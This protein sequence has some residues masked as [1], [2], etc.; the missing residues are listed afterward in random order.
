MYQCELNVPT[1]KKRG[2]KMFSNIHMAN[3]LKRSVIIMYPSWEN[4][5]M[6]IVIYELC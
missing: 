5:V 4:E 3:I 2:T 6:A 1:G